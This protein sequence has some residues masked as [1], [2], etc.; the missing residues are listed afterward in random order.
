MDRRTSGRRA[1]EVAT[2]PVDLAVGQC[3]RAMRKR[4]GLSLES[5]ATT[6]GLSIGFLSQ[7]ER[8]L[9]SPTLRA[10][11]SLA[12]ALGLSIAALLRDPADAIGE[13]PTITR[14]AS[15][16]SLLLWKSGI[17]KAVLA[18]GGASSGASFSF[19]VMVFDVHASSGDEAY[20][21][22]GQE[23]GYVL[24]GRLRL[25]IDEQS[26][27]LDPGDSFHFASGQPHRFENAARRRTSVVMLNLHEVAP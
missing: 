8:G 10:L 1:A 12:D 3:I 9:S 25:S 27:M 19:C 26:W 21:H 14:G 18:G 11:T 5:I 16:S 2:E 4:K 20:S 17:R 23:A 22:Q 13:T 6:T 7:I 24:E 15:R